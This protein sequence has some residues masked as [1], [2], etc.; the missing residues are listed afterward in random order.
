MPARLILP[1]EPTVP[2]TPKAGAVKPGTG[3]VA[4]K[5]LSDALERVFVNAKLALLSE[6]PFSDPNTG[7][8]V[9]VEILPVL[10]TPF[11]G[12][13]NGA[14]GMV[15]LLIPRSEQLSRGWGRL[16]PA[17]VSA[18]VPLALVM[19]NLPATSEGRLTTGQLKAE[20]WPSKI[21]HSH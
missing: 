8:I 1:L 3:I 6:K 14:P 4:E 20:L 21:R 5:L 13:T 7:E 17:P 2:F 18:G 12:T 11:F 10:N 19:E 15:T 9:P 16:R